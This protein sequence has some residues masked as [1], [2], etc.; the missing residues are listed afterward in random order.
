MRCFER[1]GS[2]CP[3][4]EACQT[5]YPCELVREVAGVVGTDAFHDSVTTELVRLTLGQ[6]GPGRP[7]LELE[8]PE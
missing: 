8:P 2:E 7:E 3:D 6:R 5:G 1:E 4:A